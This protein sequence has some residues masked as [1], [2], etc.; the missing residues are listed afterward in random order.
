MIVIIDLGLNNIKSISHKI[1]KLKFNTKICT[2]P[3]D[4]ISAKKIILP[5]IGHFKAG[6]Q[7]LFEQNL[8]AVLKKKVFEDEVPI[9]GI[10]MGAQLLTEKSE[11]GNVNGLGWLSAETVKF[12]FE[13][14]KKLQI[15]HV[16]WNQLIINNHSPI[17][18]GIEIDSRFYFTHSYHFISKDKNQIVTETEYG[19]K[20]PSILQD[21]N[22]IAV[23]FHPEKSHKQG[24]KIIENFLR[25]DFK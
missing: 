11:E 17:L 15:P 12:D 8:V 10:C 6:M 4:I 1:E 9:L 20:F 19:Y 23:Q 14:S 5:G 22:I 16:G 7:N 13:N 25:Y 18:D 3:E 21:N 2:Q 24:M